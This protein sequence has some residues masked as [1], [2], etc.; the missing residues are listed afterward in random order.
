MN[1]F[2]KMTTQILL[3]GNRVW[4]GFWWVSSFVVRVGISSVL[5]KTL[6]L[7]IICLLSDISGFGS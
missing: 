2:L 7:L 5:W 4:D 6:L 1:P 3:L